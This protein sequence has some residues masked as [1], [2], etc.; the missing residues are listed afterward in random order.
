MNGGVRLKSIK[1]IIAILFVS[2]I[3]NVSGVVAYFSDVVHVGAYKLP[4][5]QGVSSISNKEKN[6]WGP[7]VL[8]IIGTSHNRDVQF[9]IY[10]KDV[11]A[12]ANFQSLSVGSNEV[13][14]ALGKISATTGALSYS[15]IVEGIKTLKLRTTATWLSDTSFSGAWWLSLNDWEQLYGKAKYTGSDYITKIK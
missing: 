8:H 9:Q 13:T 10:D 3:F 1:F 15:A 7:E 6:E 14:Y 12:T 5:F 4:A 2:F 11:G